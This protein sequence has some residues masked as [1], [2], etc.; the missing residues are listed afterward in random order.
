[1]HGLSY[2]KG[3]T[4]LIKLILGKYKPIAGQIKAFGYDVFSKHSGMIGSGVGYQPQRWV[5]DY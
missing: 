3:K 2:S 4:T 1:M 5:N